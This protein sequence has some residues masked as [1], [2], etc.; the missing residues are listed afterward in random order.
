M[1]APLT[2]V[3]PRRTLVI[4]A[5]L[6]ALAVLSTVLYLTQGGDDKGGKG[7]PKGGKSASAGATNGGTDKGTYAGKDTGKGKDTGTGGGKDDT[8][9]SGAAAGQPSGKPK[10]DDSAGGNGLPAGYA[11]MSNDRFH[12][13]VAMPKG[14]KLTG[15]AGE[16]SGGIF[17]ADDGFPRIQVDFNPSP[18]EDAAAAWN[19]AMPGTRD[20]SSGYKHLGIR[21][22][23]YNG[24][25][26]VADWKF[27][28]N[29]DGKR[30]RVLNRGFKVDATHGYSIMITC[31]A[32]EWGS[33]ECET[34]RKTAFATF[35]PKD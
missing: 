1:R 27:E 7:K 31:V 28:R 21:A 35:K 5:V 3:V 34:L 18:K 11:M 6:A 15:I 29:Q 9:G 32:S 10:T 16:N 25:P 2:D 17:S 19:A 20:S 13:I 12:F 14:F 33:A 26:T 30:V 23:E 8:G 24:Y 4:I 22:V